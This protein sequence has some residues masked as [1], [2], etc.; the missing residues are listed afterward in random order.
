MRKIKIITDSSSD[1]AQEYYETHEIEVVPFSVSFDRKTYF[2][3]RVDI[4][5]GDFYKRLRDEDV[6]L[7]T[8]A[9]NPEQYR[10]VFQKALEDGMD[11]ICLCLTSKFSASYQNAVVA[12]VEL[13]EEYPGCKIAVIDSIQASCGQGLVLNEIVRMRGQ[14]FEFDNIIA[15]IEECKKTA[16]VFFAVDSLDYLTKG[17][18]VGKVAALAGSVLNIK[19]VIVMK[20]GELIPVCKVRGSRGSIQRVFELTV[21]HIGGE[22]D[23]YDLVAIH[24]DRREEAESL[25]KQLEEEGFSLPLGIENVGVT[26]GAHSGPTLLGIALIKRFEGAI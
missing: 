12:K 20:D 18:R 9:P 16:H 10:S 24:A 14:G 26:I 19:P 6:Y 25:H 23:K 1:F 17:G 3:E 4:T 15:E 8:S 11:V 2:R 22:K 13:T 7:L 21:A 5:I